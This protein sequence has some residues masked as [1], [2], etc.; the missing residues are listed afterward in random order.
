[1]SWIS[2]TVSSSIGRKIVMAVTG[3]FLCSFLVVHLIGNLQLFKGDGGLAFNT[4][5]HFMSTNPLI[6]VAEIILVA[7]FVFHIYESVMLTRR[8]QAARGGQGYVADHI[9]QNSDWK[10]RNMG[11]LGSVILVFQIGRASCRERVCSTV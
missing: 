1:M 4:Y 8:N 10:S 7:G 9:E 6:R 5:S 3:L 2:N 11:L